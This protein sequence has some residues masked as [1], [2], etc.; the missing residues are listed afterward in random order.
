M[1]RMTIRRLGLGATV[2]VL[3]VLGL[4]DLVQHYATEPAYALAL[5]AARALP[6]L[7][8]RRWPLAA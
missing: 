1:G 4:F 6:L 2:A 5:S 8:Y 7:A 3:L